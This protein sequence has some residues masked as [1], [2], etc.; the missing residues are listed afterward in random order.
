MST[1]DPKM[2]AMVD[3][4]MAQ[5]FA[6]EIEWSKTVQVG[7]WVDCSDNAT[8]LSGPQ[9]KTKDKLYQVREV[10]IRTDQ[11]TGK[12]Y[13]RSVI[14][15]G[16]YFDPSRK[17]EPERVWM[18]NGR[19]IVRNGVIIWESSLQ[20]RIKEMILNPPAELSESDFV[21]LKG[22]AYYPNL[23]SC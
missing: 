11:D 7:D 9:Y 2:D 14:V 23:G 19:V 18:G 3:D 12:V 16:D 15:D 8:Y 17:G 21:K 1:E 10:D 6:D 20:K 4:I 5:I 22:M 13:S